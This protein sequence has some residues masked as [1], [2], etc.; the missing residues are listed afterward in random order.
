LP[1][2][3]HYNTGST[4]TTL[5]TYYPA[6]LQPDHLV[7]YYLDTSLGT[8]YDFIIDPLRALDPV[9]QIIGIYDHPDIVVDVAPAGRAVVE[10]PIALAE[11]AAVET[12]LET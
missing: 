1:P 12:T 5:T 10:T 3:F 6:Q 2:T 9:D 4:Q 8:R 7:E 11:I